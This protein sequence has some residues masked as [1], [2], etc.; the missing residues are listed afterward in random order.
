[1]E[2]YVI[3]FKAGT[4]WVPLSKLYFEVDRKEGRVLRALAGR[5]RRAPDVEFR[6]GLYRNSG[7]IT[8]KGEQ[9]LLAE[10]A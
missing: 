6:V 9:E 2:Y 1:M 7:C 8:K 5:R 4:L 10:A 3:E